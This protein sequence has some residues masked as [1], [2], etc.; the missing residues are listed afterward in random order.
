MQGQRAIRRPYPEGRVQ[1]LTPQRVKELLGGIRG[2]YAGR[3]RADAPPE[4]LRLSLTSGLIPRARD[5]HD[6]LLD[7]GGSVAWLPIYAALG[8]KHVT[9]V[10]PVDPDFLSDISL[11]EWPDLDTATVVANAELDPYPVPDAS[12]DCVCCFEVLEHLAGD[13]MHLVSEANRVLVDGGD[14]CLTTPNVLDAENL[15]RFMFGDHPFGWSPYTNTYAD[16]HNRE[17]TPGEVLR[18]MNAG[19]F[20]T[21]R[22]TTERAHHHRNGAHR[23]LGR[24]LSLPAAMAGRVAMSLRDQFI[25]MHAVKRGP[26]ADRYPKP[27]YEFFDSND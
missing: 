7:I 2:D 14:F 6:R 12:F 19:G 27:L 22:L 11:P 23:R 3:D 26:V 17:Y 16:R 1:A 8:Y 24:L 15:G 4:L 5:G 9:L 25:F 13:P 18:L 21:Q 10:R 20:E